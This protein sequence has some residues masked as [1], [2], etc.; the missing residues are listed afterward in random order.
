MSSVVD[1]TEATA[2]RRAAIARELEV[3]ERE[4]GAPARGREIRLLG[5][6]AKPWIAAIVD[7]L[8][9]GAGER[10][11]SVAAELEQV[12]VDASASRVA[13]IV[14]ALRRTCG[15]RAKHAAAARRA[16]S[17]VL[18][19]PALDP[20]A[21]LERIADAART[22]GTTVEAF[23]QTLWSDLSNERPV[24]LPTERPD[25]LALAAF[26][27]EQTIRRAMS[28]AHDVTVRVW[29]DPRPVLQASAARGLIA[30]VTR[31]PESTRIEICGPLA[32]VHQTAVYG[33]ALA[34]IVPYIAGCKD[35]EL[36]VRCDFG[37]GETM[38]GLRPPV[39]LPVTKTHVRW[40]LVDRLAHDLAKA[41]VSVE[42]EPSPL[43]AGDRLAAPDLAFDRNGNR[44][45][46]E[47][48]GFWTEAYL[49]A[50]LERYRAANAR[51]VF[52][53]DAARCGADDTP[54]GDARVVR[55]ERRIAVGQLLEVSDER[56]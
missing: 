24:V 44:V 39:L 15:G 23:E 53:L 51:V 37:H 6:E 4:H 2:R 19:R 25:E 14:H 55:F 31:E 42:R 43:V 50:K 18:G 27:N 13:A 38:L 3:T 5:P 30:T 1:A 40:R 41:G 52:C 46:V 9:R 22:L 32:L 49:A 21:R 35:F 28:R 17:L 36:S 7:E 11:G 16:R 8:V 54:P 29:G 48:I 20:A 12:P 10:W 47:V 33:R 56:S 26:A 34:G 45:H